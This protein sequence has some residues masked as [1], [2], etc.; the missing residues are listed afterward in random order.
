MIKKGKVLEYVIKRT[1]KYKSSSNSKVIELPVLITNK[2]I[3][4]SHLRFLYSKRN[5]SQSW[6]ERNTFAVELLIKFI[7]TQSNTETLATEV[8]STFVDVLSFGTINNDCDKS[9][10]FWRPR[11]NE[12]V[13]I[14]LGHINTYCD[15]LDKVNGCELPKINSWR[16][17][18]KV[19]EKLRWCAYYKRQANSFHNH[20]NQPSKDQYSSIRS[21]QGPTR[22]LIDLEPVYRFSEQ[23][24]ERLFNHGYLLNR[25]SESRRNEDFASRLIIMLM[26]YGGLRLSECFHIFKHDINID[27]K[28]GSTLVNV[29]HPSDGKSPEYGFN[30]RREYLSVKYRLNPRNE[31]LR[32][33]KLHSGWKDPLLT[34]RNLSFEVIFYPM[35][36]AVD[37][38][39][40]LQQYLNIRIDG[41]HPYLFT[42]S[43]GG[44]ETKKN[45][46]KKYERAIRRIGLIPLKHLGTTPHAH[47]HSY[48][49]RLAVNGFS[50]LE[51][52]KAM[53]HKSHLSCLV[54]IT[55][56][57]QEIRE[58]IREALK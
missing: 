10:L 30:N 51:I 57:P 35:H 14:L 12:D 31:Y 26:H 21:I 45:F 7:A 42:N 58:K 37:F 48:G 52:Q 4:I 18:T 34:N 17:A 53:H 2:G 25:T 28:T 20:L 19:E 6:M 40:V 43:Y 3:L 13:N 38:T 33:H 29:F 8:L 39:L 56:T 23:H 49:H 15:Y 36:K 44:P 9:K 24:F 1:V 50:Q 54:Y 22:H 46:I 41:N 11:R 32:K 27:N 55:P 16:K 47:R 5:K